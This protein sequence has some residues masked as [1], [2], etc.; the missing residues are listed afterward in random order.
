M[1]TKLLAFLV[2]ISL[3]LVSCSRNKSNEGQAGGRSDTTVQ[4]SAPKPVTDE[5]VTSSVTNKDGIKLDMIYNNTKRTATF[6]LNGETIEMKQDTT[7]SGI[8][9]S[10]KNYL[11][12]EWHGQIELK[13]D[14][15]TI[16]K[17]Y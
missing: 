9:Y 12:S 3:I 13:K 15:K 4:S 10:N 11:Y 1:T 14:G 6:K 17:N 2:M 16:Y 7:A 5:I 8:R